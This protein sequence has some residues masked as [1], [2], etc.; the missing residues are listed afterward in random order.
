MTGMYDNFPDTFYEGPFGEF[1]QKLVSMEIKTL[2]EF[3]FEV[4]Q[5][6]QRTGEETRDGKMENLVKQL[7][8]FVEE[9]RKKNDVAHKAHE[10]ASNLVEKS[11]TLL[12]KIEMEGR[13]KFPDKAACCPGR[14]AWKVYCIWKI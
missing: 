2:G 12:H 10:G 11:R 8:G 1:I 14:S 13:S 5:V 4:D 7:K 3:A 9:A 6:L